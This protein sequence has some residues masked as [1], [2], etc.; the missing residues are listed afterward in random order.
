MHIIDT[1][2]I[3]L[4]NQQLFVMNKAFKQ[5]YY[6]LNNNFLD[7]L[8]GFKDIL[9]RFRQTLSPKM[10]HI[11]I[12][13]PWPI[14]T[15]SFFNARL[16]NF[17][18]LLFVDEYLRNWVDKNGYSFIDTNELSFNWKINCVKDAIYQTDFLQNGTYDDNS[19]EYW[20]EV[21]GFLGKH[22]CFKPADAAGIHLED[23][24]RFIYAQIVLNIIQQRQKMY[25]L[26]Q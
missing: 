22:T 26:K 18:G 25:G 15:Q 24:G 16:A 6:H 13:S 17:E 11:I 4:F 8:N 2:N 21:Q 23:P 10:L 9:E 3:R 20:N 19:R 7:L 5:K 1:K 14:H 12:R